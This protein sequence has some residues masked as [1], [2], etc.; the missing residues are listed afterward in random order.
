[1]SDLGNS[2]MRS[3]RSAGAAP[4][5]A[6]GAPQSAP[7]Q[8]PV[9][10]APVDPGYTSIFDRFWTDDFS[11]IPLVGPASAVIASKTTEL[12][13]QWNQGI[14]WGISALPGGQDTYSW[15]QA[16]Q[17]SPGQSALTYQA[18]LQGQGGLIGAAATAMPTAGLT[19]AG[20]LEDPNNPLYDPNFDVTNEEQRNRAFE[21]GGVMQGA[22]GLNDGLAAF[23]LDPLVLGGKGIKIARFGSDALAWGDKSF[24]GLTNRSIAS[25]RAVNRIGDE[26]D[27]AMS[28]INSADDNVLGVVADE[29]VRGDFTAL[30][31]LPQFQNAHR[32]L[33]A[34]IGADITDKAD[35]ITF[36]AAA[37]GN[38]KY[39][40]KLHSDH[41][42]AYDAL[43]RV[44]E[45]SL[46]EKAH[47][48][49]KPGE[50]QPAVLANAL[51][52]EV[53][54]G[55]LF[56]DLARRNAA[57]SKAV[58][59]IDQGTQLITRMGV[60]D[61]PLGVRAAQIAAAHRANKMSRA[62][63]GRGTLPAVFETV[64]QS[65]AAKRAVRV[66]E[67][68]AGFHASG[69]VDVKG[70]NVGKSSDEIAAALSDS[71]TIRK[72]KDFVRQQMNLFGSAAY[73]MDRTRVVKQIENNALRYLASKHGVTNEDL[74]KEVY[75][76]LD[77]RR[78]DMVKNF[79]DRTYG[80]DPTDG[81]M[82]KTGPV[83]TSQ[84]ETRMPMLDMKVLEDS[85]KIA[86]RDHYNW[87]FREKAWEAADATK[88]FFDELQ[89][90]W[91]ASVLLRLGYTQRNVGEGWL[92]S[93]AVLGTIPS[94]Q[95]PLTSLKNLASNT[96]KRFDARYVRKLTAEEETLA[97]QVVA[98]NKKAQTLTDPDE[99]KA[100]ADRVADWNSRLDQIRDIRKAQRTRSHL[101]DSEA[102]AGDLGQL[103]RDQAS[104]AQTTENFLQSNWARRL[105]SSLADSQWTRINPGKP[106]YWDE[107][108]GAIR[109]FRNDPPSL[110]ALEGKSM[111]EIT[112]W[113]HSSEATLYRR[114]MRLTHKMVD[115]F[116]ASRV[117]MVEKYLPTED[118][119]LL[120][121]S[122]DVEASELETALG[123]LAKVKPPKEPNPKRFFKDGE[124]NAVS[125]D[126]AM[127]KYQSNLDAY[128]G[129]VGLSPIHGREIKANMRGG[130]GMAALAQETVINPLF[131]VLGTLPEAV[132]VRQPFYNEVWKRSMLRSQQVAKGQGVDLTKDVL[133]RMNTVAHREA[134]RATNETLYTIERQSNPAALLR[135][136]MPFFPA[137]ENSAKVWLGII[138][139]DPSVAVRASLLWNIPNQMGMVYDE[140][141]NKVGAD[142]IGFLNGSPNRFIR[143][144]E[145]MNAVFEKF[146][147][148]VPFAVPQG[149]V[150]VVTPGETPFLAGLGPIATV[151][152][153]FVLASKPNAQEWLRKTFGEQL[154]QQIA[155]FGQVQNDPKAFAPAWMRFGIT[156]M[157][158]ESD[159]DY[160][161]TID[162][163]MAN[164]M[165]EWNL[166]GNDPA[167]KPDY[168]EVVDRARSFYLFRVAASLTSPAAVT[169]MSKYQ[170]QIDFWRSLSEN[171]RPYRENV[172][173]FITK[174]GDSY[175][176]LIVST[177]KYAAG[178]INPSL[179]QY[180]MLSDNADLVRDIAA[181]DPEAVG[182]LASSGPRG[183]FNQGVYDYLGDMVVPGT[184]DTY[185]AKKSPLEMQESIQMQAAWREYNQM[186][187]LRDEALQ[188]LG[189]KSMESAAAAGVKAK[190]NEFVGPYMQGKYGNQWVVNYGTFA[191]KTPVYLTTVNM[192]LNNKPF[193]DKHG[194]SP[195][196]QNI[197]SYMDM[198]QLALDAIAQGADS[199]AVNKQF[200]EW[201][202]GFKDTSLEFSD[203]YDS[204]LDNDALSKRMGA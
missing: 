189:V 135:W 62:M 4:A 183:E 44:A 111:E 5:P 76:R 161:A 26:A 200:K 158:G 65:S 42:S 176:P 124:F 53:D 132:L 203:F 68:T 185:R 17:V 14:S 89:S 145:G 173:T 37:A 140:K 3:V 105:N 108:A 83:M 178:N 66:W 61:T 141:G 157:R 12:Y 9:Q 59:Q 201:A 128:Q 74:I 106:Q 175:L 57:L 90:L 113:L 126:R 88:N 81:S 51:E 19:L 71:R 146:S 32:D 154:Y 164:A 153:G 187:V 136:V 202:G 149:A 159:A 43:K 119:R 116:A 95:H 72:D 181:L 123:A 109:Q 64:F 204:Y 168:A 97:K 2:V 69:Y 49:A 191:D 171:D 82:I 55:K 25:V 156:L 147:G 129:Q 137:W 35:A 24:A 133:E 99:V 139:R 152:A 46:V 92:R 100:L 79:K 50:W 56:E 84:L 127:K 6:A 78:F 87:A 86:A 1:M 94:F 167:L 166:A 104:G 96:N 193:M 60:A 67:W 180:N 48:N 38:A 144:P 85:V 34:S 77:E 27:T 162:S 121:A 47:L 150:N 101:G 196:W 120:A 160:L 163:M 45:P 10:A 33:L 192:A 165:V 182:V 31:E 15:E 8:N 122:R 11:A 195:L 125:Y 18:K 170:D 134:L 28:L 39:I 148:G 172:D 98:A 7:V 169:R 130:R 58:G 20:K 155:P 194:D 102:F 179:V 174:F 131:K 91:K 188:Q 13:N 41:L 107:L 177:S 70:P 73:A 143:L 75:R 186:K 138:A 198:R 103:Y 114:D 52:A 199:T 184:N 16:G 29:V 54:A 110:M 36:L 197:R 142:P 22:S 115:D 190:W 23:F 80:I 151:P 40:S 21:S 30:R 63:G 112:K 93:A 118:S 117:G